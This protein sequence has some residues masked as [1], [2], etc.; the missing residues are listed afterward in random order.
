MG[1][2]VELNQIAEHNSLQVHVG[3]N[4]VAGGVPAAGEGLGGEDH[5]GVPV[6]PRALVPLGV[7][8]ASA[9]VSSA[10]SAGGKRQEHENRKGQGQ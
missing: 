8:P 10:A 7:A 6:R 9:A 4:R 3:Q 1:F 2:I 5:Q